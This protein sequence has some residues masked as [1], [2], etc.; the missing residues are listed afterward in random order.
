MGPVKLRN[1]NLLACFSH[2]M[3]FDKTQP[4]VKKF[5]AR[6]YGILDSALL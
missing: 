5:S 1:T 6:R 3:R 2:E 4:F